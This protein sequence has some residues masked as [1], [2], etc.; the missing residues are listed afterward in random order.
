M[1]VRNFTYAYFLRPVYSKYPNFNF[2]KNNNIIYIMNG[3]MPETDELYEILTDTEFETK[4]SDNIVNKIENITL[5]YR[6]PKYD[7][8]IIEKTPKDAIP[9]EYNIDAEIKWVAIYLNS[10]EGD[11]K[12]FLFTDNVGLWED[13]NKFVIFESLTGTQGSKNILKDIKMEI[14][15]VSSFEIMNVEPILVEDNVPGVITINPFNDENVLYDNQIDNDLIVSGKAIGIETGQNV[16]LT[17]NNKIYNGIVENQKWSITIPSE[18]LQNLELDKEYTITAEVS[19]VAGNR[20]STSYTFTYKHYNQPP[21]VTISPETL[22]IAPSE[23]AEF[24]YSIDDPDSDNFVISVSVEKGSTT[25]DTD[26]KIITYTAPDEEGTDTL[27]LTVSDGDNT[28]TKIVEI[29]IQS[30]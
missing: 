5:S 9:F 11:R 18:D 8:I 1:R 14:R 3:D 20:S 13:D 17:F 29:E 25:I 30:N 26:N 10:Y 27:K 7:R 15:D 12:Y 4:Y 16:K 19:D 6:S 24:T 22:T 2:D 21:V 28:I 23:T